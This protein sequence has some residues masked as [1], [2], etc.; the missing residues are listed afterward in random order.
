[1]ADKISREQRSRVM[2]R[3]RSFNTRPELLVRSLL[4]RMGFRFRL[5]RRDLPGSPDLCL[6]KY[7]AAIFVHGCFWHCHSC[8]HGSKRPASNQQYWSQKLQGNVRRDAAAISAL[9]VRGWKSL[10][11]WECE[12]KS[13]KLADRV[14]KFLLAER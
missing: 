13:P 8:S 12:L 11:I 6:P 7:R 5:H 1:M 2:S 3:V 10:V 14:R 4:H 9:R